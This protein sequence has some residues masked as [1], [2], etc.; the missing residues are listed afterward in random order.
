MEVYAERIREELQ[1]FY[2][3]CSNHNQA[4]H[5]FIEMANVGN[6]E[7]AARCQ[8]CASA[9]LD[10]AMDSYMSVCRMQIENSRGKED[11][12]S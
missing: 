12:E 2:L 1:N 3:A 4:Y 5:S 7:D 10:S 6:W 9:M 11:A 8:L